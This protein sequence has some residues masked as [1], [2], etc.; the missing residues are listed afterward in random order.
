[1][2]TAER[3]IPS[4]PPVKPAVSVGPDA[5]SPLW[6]VRAAVPP[7]PVVSVAFAVRRAGS[8]SWKRLDVDTSPPFRA[9]LDPATFAHDEKVSLVAV[10]RGLDGRTAVSKVVSFRV[11]VR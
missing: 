5:Q 3:R 8:S 7:A 9:F 10:A 6:V 11:R 4:S 2:M 1:M